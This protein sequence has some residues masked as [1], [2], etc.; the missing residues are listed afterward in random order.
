MTDTGPV[1]TGT[2]D[3]VVFAVTRGAMFKLLLALLV[4]GLFACV[5]AVKVWFEVDAHTET[6]REVKTEMRDLQKD[7]TELRARKP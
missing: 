5:G 6:L 4:P 3:D 1:K 2:K 7:V